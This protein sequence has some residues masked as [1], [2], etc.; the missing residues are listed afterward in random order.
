MNTVKIT[1]LCC[2]VC[3]FF[4]VNVYSQSSGDQSLTLIV[5][6]QLTNIHTNITMVR[7]LCNV[8]D[9]QGVDV[10]IG[11]ESKDIENGSIQEDFTIQIITVGGRN[12]NEA[13]SYQCDL[14]LYGTGWAIPDDSGIG[15]IEYQADPDQPFIP[16]VTGRIE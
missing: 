13:V 9:G 11:N 16:Q 10:G 2:F 14:Q 15:E 4:I 12:L 1:V 6:V 8:K 3:L 5:P 7:V